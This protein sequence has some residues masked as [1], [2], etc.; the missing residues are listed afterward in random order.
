MLTAITSGS[1]RE[2]QSFLTEPRNE[3]ATKR[4]PFFS[5]SRHAFQTRDR[6]LLGG[7]YVVACYL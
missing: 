7:F 2:K 4:Y 3:Q 5:H 1:I 6:P